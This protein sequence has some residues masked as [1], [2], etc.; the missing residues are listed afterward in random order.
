MIVNQFNSLPCDKDRTAADTTN[1]KIKSTAH[2]NICNR[3]LT[4]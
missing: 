1:D 4:F 3:T 2:V